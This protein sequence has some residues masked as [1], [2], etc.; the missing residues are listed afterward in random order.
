MFKNE[1][2]VDTWDP[3]LIS[4]KVK[5]FLYHVYRLN[6]LTHKMPQNA[7]PTVVIYLISISIISIYVK[8]RKRPCSAI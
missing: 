6:K 1:V 3:I 4:K 8:K 5:R 2:F 7:I